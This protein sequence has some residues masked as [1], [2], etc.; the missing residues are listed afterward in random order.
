[1]D[2]LELQR[3]W[4]LTS[5]TTDL[6][7]L[8]AAVTTVK[9]GEPIEWLGDSLSREDAQQVIDEFKQELTKVLNDKTY[10]PWLDLFN[11]Y[12]NEAPEVLTN[13]ATSTFIEPK[14]V[15]ESLNKLPIEE[16]KPE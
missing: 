6:N 16:A 14:E 1:M 15:D 9:D 12:K 13:V 3:K 7:Y 4:Y 11:Q 10:Q 2:K 8:M 5:I